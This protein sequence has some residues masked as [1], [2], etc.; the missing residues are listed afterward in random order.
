MQ[1]RDR[2]LDFNFRKLHSARQAQ[3]TVNE[4][5]YGYFQET[6]ELEAMSEDERFDY[7]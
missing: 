7:M 6:A 1:D 5:C 3:L 4:D 2:W